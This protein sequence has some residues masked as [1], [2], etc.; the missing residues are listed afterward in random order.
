[1][2]PLCKIGESQECGRQDCITCTKES[3]GKEH[4]PCT[5]RS[6]LYEYICRSG[7]EETGK[8]TPPL[9]MPSI[10]VGESGRSLYKR[11][12]EHWRA[13]RNKDDDSHILKHQVLHH[14]GSES[15]RFHFRPVKFFQS[16]LGRQIA[17]AVRIEKLG[18]EV[19]L[20]GVGSITTF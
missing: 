10:Y 2:F 7:G 20:R 5:K 18:E 11:G 17:E 4:P 13:F 8:L 6:V 15:P 3:R 12:K 19:V 9:E 1:M 16:A 14:G